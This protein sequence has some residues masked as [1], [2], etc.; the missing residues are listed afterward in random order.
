MENF[1]DVCAGNPYLASKLELSRWIA[2]QPLGEGRTLHVRVHTLYGGQPKPHMFLGQMIRA[3]RDGKA[4]EMTSG[5]QLRE[6]QHVADLA[7]AFEAL[8]GLDWREAHLG[9]LLEINSGKPVR[10]ADLARAVF[11]ACGHPELLKIGSLARPQGE[12]L[13]RAFPPS[14]AWLLPAA[15]DAIQGVVEAV[16]REVFA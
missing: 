9:P 1:P 8:L 5:E 11:D 15:R 14:P 16:R 2:S 4:F 7:F 6:Y 12:N 3:L 10:L 13:N